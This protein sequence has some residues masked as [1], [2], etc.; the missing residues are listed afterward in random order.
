MGICLDHEKK[1]GG[2]KPR[3]YGKRTKMNIGKRG[4]YRRWWEQF[5]IERSDRGV[6]A[7]EPSQRERGGGETEEA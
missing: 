7:Q 4:G 6:L 1:R 5:K 2:K 3:R